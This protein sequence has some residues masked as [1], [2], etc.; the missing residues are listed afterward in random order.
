MR[1]FD[2]SGWAIA[3]M[4]IGVSL[5]AT[6]RADERIPADASAQPKWTPKIYGLCMELA[7]AKQRP[8]AEQARMLRRTRLRRRRLSALARRE[9]RRESTHARRG[10]AEAL[11]ALCHGQRESRGPPFD[12]R[13]PAA[14]R[15]LKGRPV[16]DLRAPATAFRRAIRGAKSRRSRS[17]ANLATWPPRPACGS[18]STTTRATGPQ[19]CRSRC[20]IV[21]ED[22]PSAASGSNF[23]LCHWLMVDGDKDYR[24]V[25][26]ENAAKIFAVTINGAKLG[27]KTWTNGLIQPLDQGDFDNRQLLATLREIGYRGPI[28]LMCYGIP[29]DAREHLERSMNTWKKLRP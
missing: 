11:P 27:S 15:K 1:K 22:E 13:L 16:D 14:I 4:L 18:R 9:P 10:R 5:A 26:R 28:G 17:S 23:N 2:R 24:P 3:A 25:L 8:L 6:S 7:D 19:A 21:D 20:E 29:G 12:P